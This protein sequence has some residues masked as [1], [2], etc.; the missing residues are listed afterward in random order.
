[1]KG[2]S[3]SQKFQKN[4]RKTVSFHLTLKA[5]RPQFPTSAETDTKKNVCF[6]CFEM[7]GSFPKKN[8]PWIHLIEVTGLLLG[9]INNRKSYE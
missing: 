5:C 3:K 4:P 6:E 2:F 8:L 7:N 9:T 1:M